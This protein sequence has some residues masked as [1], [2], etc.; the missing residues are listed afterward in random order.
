MTT[1]D[2]R[3]IGQLLLGIEAVEAVDVLE[4]ADGDA[5][6]EVTLWGDRVS[7]AV[8]GVLAG[9]GVAI[10]PDGTATRGDPTHT[11]L[12]VRA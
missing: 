7:S 12:V 4:G 5:V 10:D 8:L 9:R 2:L 1:H 11:R 3:E 6:L